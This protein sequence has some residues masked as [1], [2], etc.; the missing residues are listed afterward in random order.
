MGGKVPHDFKVQMMERSVPVRDMATADNIS[1]A[2][3]AY[4]AALVEYP[5]RH[6]VLSHG[7]R[8]IREQKGEGI[9]A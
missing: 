6:I 5:D 8:I 9:F 3:A 4:R 7:M 1:I 2:I